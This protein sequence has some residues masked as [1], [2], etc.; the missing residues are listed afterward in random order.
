MNKAEIAPAL[1]AEGRASLTLGRSSQGIVT[2]QISTHTLGRID[3]ELP[4]GDLENLLFGLAHVEARLVR[5]IPERTPPYDKPTGPVV[6]W[7]DDAPDGQVWKCPDCGMMASLGCNA[8]SHRDT[9]HHGEP[10]LIPNPS[11]KK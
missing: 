2:L 7:P 8:G 4:T 9:R 10:S 1:L 6:P 3:L 11:K 5:A